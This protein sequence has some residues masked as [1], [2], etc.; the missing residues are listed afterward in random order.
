[1][2]FMR[3]GITVLICSVAVCFPGFGCS[4]TL[5]KPKAAAPAAIST[6]P[7]QPV[8]APPAP[9]ATTTPVYV[10]DLSHVGE[11]LPD[12][13]LAWDNLMKVTEAAADQAQARFTFN[14]TNVSNGNVAV[15]SVHPS[16][17]CTTAQL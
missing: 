4:S 13:I 3:Y 7:P 9:V 12:G 14:L 2:N 8:L 16:C 17:G 5:E 10:P 11:P 1:M 6:P 15:V